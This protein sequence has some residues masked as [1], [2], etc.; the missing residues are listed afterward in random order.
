MAPTTVM[1]I[2]VISVPVK[3]YRATV[4]GIT[5]SPTPLL[6]QASHEADD[7]HPPIAP[8]THL[9]HVKSWTT[10][11]SATLAQ[12]STISNAGCNRR[13]RM[14]HRGSKTFHPSGPY[15]RE[16]RSNTQQVKRPFD[17]L[18]P[19]AYG[20]T[21]SASSTPCTLSLVLSRNGTGVRGSH[22]RHIRRVH[23]P[24][25]ILDSYFPY[26]TSYTALVYHTPNIPLQL[27]MTSS[28]YTIQNASV[29]ASGLTKNTQ[30]HKIVKET[31]FTKDTESES[32][33]YAWDSQNIVMPRG[34]TGRGPPT[35]LRTC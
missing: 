26:S 18:S 32:S 10:R 5:Q 22:G 6:S 28:P 23:P 19:D 33:L 24:R 15:A 9:K 25:L 13:T 35:S 3:P 16:S 21:P 1:P 20:A 17:H 29:A 2:W 11:N 4:P 7:P 27:S 8:F 34:L 14:V 12:S 31:G 30:I